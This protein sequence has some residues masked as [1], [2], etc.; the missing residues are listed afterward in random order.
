MKRLIKILFG[1]IVLLI[2]VGVI[3]FFT[4]TFI[5]ERVLS[6]KLGATVRINEINFNPPQI[7]VDDAK[8]K[9]PKGFKAPNALA[10]DNIKITAPYGNYLDKVIN[11]DEIAL[12]NILLVLE[13]LQKN[14]SQNNWTELL[15]NINSES[16]VSNEGGSRHAIIKR[17]VLTNITIRIYNASGSY[18]DKVI[19]RIELKDIKTA[20][21][22]L[23][24]RIMQ[25]II[26]ELLFNL[27]DLLKL[28]LEILNQDT[29]KGVFDKVDS[30]IPFF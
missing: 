11:I 12:D 25:A 2:I 26:S 14:P 7:L 29:I 21:G 5:T 19:S 13:P 3:L 27:N 8:L 1:I 24:R 20:D 10:V 6:S 30:K 9:N 17:L 16:K 4:R 18:Q 23:A 22:D 15:G 28:P